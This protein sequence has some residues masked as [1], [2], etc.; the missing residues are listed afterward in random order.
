MRYFNVNIAIPISTYRILAIFVPFLGVEL[1]L[2]K[3]V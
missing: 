2:Y 3:V 1:P